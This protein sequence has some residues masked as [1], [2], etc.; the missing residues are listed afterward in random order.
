MGSEASR[1]FQETRSLDLY[2][3]HEREKNSKSHSALH[4]I[5]N[6]LQRPAVTRRD[7]ERLARTQDKSDGQHSVKSPRK[8]TSLLCLST[9]GR[10]WDRKD[11]DASKLSHGN[12][13]FPVLQKALKHF[14]VR[15]LL[16][17]DPEL[18]TATVDTPVW[19]YLVHHGG[20][21]VAMRQVG[22]HELW[23]NLDSSLSK[24]QLM[25]AAEVLRLQIGMPPNSGG[26]VLAVVGPTPPSPMKTGGRVSRLSVDSRS[27]CMTNFNL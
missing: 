13:P 17:T 25:T 26:L 18:Q 20:Q 16:T 19:G 1:P 14:G 23:V 3:Y 2:V 15:V 24:P 5:N 6:L 27:I 9:A 22:E 12:V 7:L 4:A 21:W 11:Q 10:K 8:K